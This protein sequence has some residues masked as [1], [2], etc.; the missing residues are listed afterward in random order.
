[1]IRE[2]SIA[3]AVGAVLVAGI[4]AAVPLQVIAQTTTQPARMETPLD[5]VQAASVAERAP[6]LWVQDATSYYTTRHQEM[7]SPPGPVNATTPPPSIGSQLK[8]TLS[9]GLVQW[10]QDVLSAWIAALPPGGIITALTDADADGVRNRLDNCPS[11]AN[12]DQAD[13]DGDGVGDVCDNCASV[14]NPDQTDTDGNGVGDA[15]EGS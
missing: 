6:G 5:H 9:Q 13:T 4:L 14:S 2:R 10:F 7:L 11:V 15:C 3:R 8:D 12:A 1:M